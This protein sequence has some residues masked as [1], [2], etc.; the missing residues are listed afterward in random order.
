M[1]PILKTKG[2]SELM[3]GREGKGADFTPAP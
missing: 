1:D 2:R 3:E